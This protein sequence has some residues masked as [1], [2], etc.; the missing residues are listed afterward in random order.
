MGG[1]S[2]I[3]LALLCC[4]KKA[5]RTVRLIAARKCFSRTISLGGERGINQRGASPPPVPH[6]TYPRLFTMK[7]LYSILAVF[8]ANPS[9]RIEFTTKESTATPCLYFCQSGECPIAGDGVTLR[10]RV[11]QRRATL[12]I[13]P[14]SSM[15][16]TTPYTVPPVHMG[17]KRYRRL[18]T[19]AHW[20]GPEACEARA[21]T[22]AR[23][24][25]GHGPSQSQ[26]ILE[27]AG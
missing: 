19:A 21:N 13:V 1:V 25:P 17:V 18:F 9:R 5:S 26:P 20:L 16:W 2:S 6:P 15:E 10:R 14:T 3:Q 24:H 12:T 4:S 8:P 22:T 23:A 27:G 7:R 11:S